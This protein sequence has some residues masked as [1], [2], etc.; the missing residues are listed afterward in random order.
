M[1]KTERKLPFAVRAAATVLLLLLLFAVPLTAFCAEGDAGSESAET[2]SEPTLTDTGEGA[3]FSEIVSNFLDRYSGEI[4]SALSL[5]GTLVLAWLAR[6]GL[7]PALRGGLDGLAAGVDRLSECTRDAGERQSRLLS[8][9]VSDAE[10]ILSDLSG[11]RDLF[12]ALSERTAELERKTAEAESERE[13]LMALNR[14]S[15]E[16]LKEVFTA[17]RLPVTSKEELAAIYRRALDAVAGDGE[18]T[19]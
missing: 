2:P 14:A 16:M 8:E 15:V 18:A 6:R 9:F 12:A 11:V 4:F 17:A 19:P 5:V 13:K 7:L 1:V 10:P 3:D